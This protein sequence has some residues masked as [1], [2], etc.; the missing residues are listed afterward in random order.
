MDWDLK[1][2]TA[3]INKMT[4]KEKIVFIET[5]LGISGQMAKF[6]IKFQE[7]IPIS[8][9]VD[10]HYMILIAFTNLNSLSHK[11]NT[12]EIVDF[13]LRSD[14]YEEK[15]IDVLKQLNIIYKDKLK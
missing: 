10:I 15:L 1:N 4:N 3:N 14:S 6:L 2:V 9:P 8:L 5:L 11:D 12:G 7:R 13:S